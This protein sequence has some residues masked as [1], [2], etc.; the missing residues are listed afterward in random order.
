MSQTMDYDPSQPKHT[1]IIISI[2]LTIVFVLLMTIALI[3]FFKGSLKS[4]ETKNESVQ[5]NGFNLSQLNE[6]ENSYLKSSSDDKITI[7]DAIY[8]TIIRYNN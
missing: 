5:R 4:Q 2:V 3:Y 8:I 6:W 1:P 7:D